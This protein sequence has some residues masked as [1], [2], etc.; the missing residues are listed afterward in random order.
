MRELSQYSAYSD[1][2]L[3]KFALYF[4]SP[5]YTQVSPVIFL[6]FC[7]NFFRSYC[8]PHLYIILIFI[9]FFACI[10]V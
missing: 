3:I 2:L 9:Y 6:N 5:L 7:V 4:F 10:V 1:V 8:I